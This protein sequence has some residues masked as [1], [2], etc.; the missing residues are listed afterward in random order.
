MS[1]KE[2]L[3]MNIGTNYYNYMN[4]A[5]YYNS[6]FVNTKSIYNNANYN[7]FL[8]SNNLNSKNYFNSDAV[9]YVRNVKSNSAD[10][11]NVLSEISS[12]T[13]F[14]KKT[15]ISSDAESL[16]VKASDSKYY[17]FSAQSAAVKIDQVAT[18][19]INQGQALEAG[20][21]V[22]ANSG[23]QFAVDVNG[24]AYQFS[25]NVSAA[26]TNQ[27]LQQK[28]AEAINSRKIGLT[29]SVSTDA[30]KKTSTLNIQ[31]QN[32]GNDPKNRF[33][34][35]DVSG[36]TVAKTGVSTVTQAAQDAIYSVNGGSNKTSKTNTVDLGNGYTATLLK[37]SD[38]EITV[39]RGVDK[40]YAL[41][42][43][44][45]LVKSYNGLYGATLANPDDVKANRLFNQLINVSKTYASSLA[46]VGIGFDS[47]GNMTVDKG[48][49]A[50]AADDGRLEKFFTENRNTNY[51][52]TN[53]LSRI[54]D[55]AYRNTGNYISQSTMSASLS[56]YDNS[57][58]SYF[59]TSA[60]NYR[61]MYSL[62][63][64]GML[65]DFSF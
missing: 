47:S 41:G 22:G 31:S 21:K 11:K 55:N 43:I 6:L 19:Q 16:T 24:Q 53:Q 58:S 34:V 44:E 28:M 46:K 7:S 37:A 59:N 26:D 18:G 14:N 32:T 3:I 10:L 12:G 56:G 1:K 63:N 38:K 49:M 17:S 45:N 57:Y 9:Q 4:Y 15:A 30:D 42:K 13:A 20:A 27:T 51:G 29:A 35:R 65:F 23:Y 25:V 40:D 8:W 54:A 50:Q 60:N 33:T 5:N 52:Y 64:L 39:S 2:V 48:I 62:M 36:D 61:A